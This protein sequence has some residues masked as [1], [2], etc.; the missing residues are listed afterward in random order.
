MHYCLQEDLFPLLGFDQEHDLPEF[1]IFWEDPASAP[2][3]L[4][5]QVS[6]FCSLSCSAPFLS[7]ALH[8]DHRCTTAPDSIK[9]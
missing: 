6:I 1:G 2:T 7:P 5:T 4:V 9:V 3:S 8:V